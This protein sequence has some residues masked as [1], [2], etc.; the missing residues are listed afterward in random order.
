MSFNLSQYGIEVT[1]IHRNT[2]V[3][4]LY[5]LG[6]RKEKGTA[7]SDVGALLV[8]SGEKT[9]RSPKDKRIVR[10]PES[11]NNIDWGPINIELD[12]HVFMINRERAIDYLNTRERIYVVDAFAGHLHPG[13]PCFVYAEYA[14]HAHRRGTGQLWKA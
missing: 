11:E 8:Y 1:N 2:S 4:I 12:E 5:E 3:P 7:I 14:H 6:L 13:L 10:N 9:G